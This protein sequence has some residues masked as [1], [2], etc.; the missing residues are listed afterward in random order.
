MKAPRSAIGLT[1]SRGYHRQKAANRPYGNNPGPTVT[2][3][4][5]C[6]GQSVHSRR[7]AQQP[8]GSGVDDQPELNCGLSKGGGITRWL[9]RSAKQQTAATFAS[10]TNYPANNLPEHQRYACAPIF[11]IGAQMDNA[12]PGVSNTSTIWE[13]Q[14]LGACQA[15][16]RRGW[17]LPP[18]AL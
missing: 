6:S 5:Q 15:R 7:P 12:L 18:N 3:D 2:G 13:I 8:V 9:D 1:V 16:W 14:R 17:D 10:G 4:C 11:S